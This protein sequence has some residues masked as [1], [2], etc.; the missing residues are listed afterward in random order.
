MAHRIIS[1]IDK[2]G[3]QTNEPKIREFVTREKA[4]HLRADKAILHVARKEGERRQTL[5][6]DNVDASQRRLEEY[7]KRENKE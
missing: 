2:G 4:L 3:T 7:I 5:I 6:K 1:K